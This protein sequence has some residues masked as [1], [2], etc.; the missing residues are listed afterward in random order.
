MVATL[1]LFNDN[2]LSILILFLFDRR[3]PHHDPNRDKGFSK[4]TNINSV[5]FSS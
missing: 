4:E 3:P 5:I 2:F 1:S